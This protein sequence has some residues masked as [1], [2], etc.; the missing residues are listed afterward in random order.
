MSELGPDE[1]RLDET[2]TEDLASPAG[3]TWQAAEPAD[4]AEEA[5]SDAPV[6]P[7]EEGAEDIAARPDGKTWQ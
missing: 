7:V 4:P 5:A 1:G 3:K 6:E 2:A